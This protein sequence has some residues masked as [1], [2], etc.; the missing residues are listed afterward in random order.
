MH[1][2]LRL[3]PDR[4]MLLVIDLQ[5]KLLP[6]IANRDRVIEA[7]SLLIRGCRLFDI[8]VLLTE[9]YPK[10]IGSTD[11]DLA[12]LLAE[13]NATRLEKLHFS[14]CGDDKIRDAIRNIDRPQIIVIGIEAHVCVQQTVLDLL[15]MD[16]DVHVCADAIGSRYSM[17]EK[18]A[19]H[20]MRQAG[21]TIST[22][23]SALFELC[24]QCGT[25][26]FKAMSA[27]I[28]EPRS[29]MSGGKN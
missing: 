16:Y 2:Q 1:N 21:A 18:I 13:S 28:K 7:S 6:S 10:G 9:Q 4:A 5:Q 27:L 25:P 3:D 29:A 24:I 12:S 14:C 11:P 19:R 15:V 20:R 8:P 22:V 23:E 26:T 17:D